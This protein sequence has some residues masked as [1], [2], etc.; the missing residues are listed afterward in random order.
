MVARQTM[1]VVEKANLP[2]G[3]DAKPRASH[4]PTEAAGSPKGGQPRL[5][6]SPLSVRHAKPQA[7][8]DAPLRRPER[9][10]YVKKKTKMPRG[11]ANTPER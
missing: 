2:R 11:A 1:Y 5:V 7:A 9:I 3:R 6:I 4:I 8:A 10:R